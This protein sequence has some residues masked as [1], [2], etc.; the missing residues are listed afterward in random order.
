MEGVPVTGAV[1]VAPL[2][3]CGLMLLA[4][5]MFVAMFA[6]IDQAYCDA[7]LEL[8][9][10]QTTYE[11]CVELIPEVPFYMTLGYMLWLVGGIF[12]ALA[13]SPRL[14]RLLE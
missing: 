2:I 3:V 8:G 7:G 14:R 12:L 6:G 13:V 1:N 9:L 5:T 10:N 11:A 4:G